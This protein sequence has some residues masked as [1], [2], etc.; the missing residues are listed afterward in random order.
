MKFRLSKQVLAA[1]LLVSI[2]PLLFAGITARRTLLE[3]L[4]ASIG[5]RLSDEV[6][7]TGRNAW[8]FLYVAQRDAQMI[9]SAIEHGSEDP[10]VTAQMLHDVITANPTLANLHVVDEHGRVQASAQREG[11]PQSIRQLSPRLQQLYQRA[12]NAKH[13]ETLFADLGEAFEEGAR[14]GELKPASTMVLELMAPVISTNGGRR[15]LIVSLNT[16]HV[17]SMLDGYIAE[18]G[19]EGAFIVDRNNRVLFSY[20]EQIRAGSLLAKEYVDLLAQFPFE[21]AAEQ[22]IVTLQGEKHFVTSASLPGIGA[23]LG[24]Q[25]RVMVLLPYKTA[26]A[27]IEATMRKGALAFLIIIVIAAIAAL[28][29]SRSIGRPIAMLNRS[30]EAMANGDYSIRVTGSSSFEASQL[31]DA[32][33]RMSVAVSSEKQALQ[34]EIAERK[35]AQAQIRELQHR[36]E[37]ILNNAGDGL[38]GLDHEGRITF[39]N[40]HGAEL[41]ALPMQRVIGMRMS[42]LHCDSPAITGTDAQQKV[43]EQTL[44]I[45]ATDATRE[46][47][48]RRGD[49]SERA[50]EYV[51]SPLKDDSGHY[52][53]SVVVFRDISERKAHEAEL[54]A[55]R[56]AAESASRAKSEFLANMSHEIRTPMN[57]V[58]G[59]TNLLGD[60]TLSDE[61]ADY[62]KTI[63]HSAESLL[64]IINDI[65]DFSKVEAGKLSVEKIPFRLTGAVSDVA[66]LLTPQAEQK[67]LE[68]ALRIPSGIP[69]SILGDPGRVRQIVLNLMGNAIKFTQRGHVLITL[70]MLPAS[71]ARPARIRCTIAD[72]GIGI[73]QEKQALM[74]QQF[75]QADASTTRTFG[76]TGLGLA[77]SKRLVELMGGEIGFSSQEGA[78]STFWFTLPAEIAVTA[79]DESQ[80]PLPNAALLNVLVVDDLEVNRRLFGQQLTDWQIKHACASSGEEALEVLQRARVQ[81]NPFNIAVLDH[82]MPGMDGL[83]LGQR[84]KA[85][86]Q[87]NRTS[88]IMVTSGSQ[89][90]AA[91]T[92]LT[93]GFD[94]FLMKPVVRPTQ[95]QVALAKAWRAVSNE[96]VTAATTKHA[97]ASP[98]SLSA[99]TGRQR[100]VLVAEDN[101]VNQR[102][103]KHL[104]EKKLHCLVDIAEDGQQAVEMTRNTEYD[105]VLMDCYMPVMDGFEATA[106][107]RQNQKATRRLPVVALTANAMAE[108]RERC[109][110]AGMDDYLS[111]PIYPDQLS[112][113]LQRWTQEDFSPASDVEPIDRSA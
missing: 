34:Q 97:S 79:A 5:P 65:L 99:P 96:S 41:L 23:N 81:G 105:L 95:L 69:E 7:T 46:A 10:A 111:K 14:Q 57:G 54:K 108:D 103:V 20:G 59:F 60:T 30:A 1:L 28:W 15:V 37:L 84:I 32:F 64:I 90:A 42:E 35:T 62:V 58:I 80:L 77:I 113:I 29:L 16:Q 52:G 93:A 4:E 13:G 47:S 25:W 56:V 98:S 87:L 107:I 101:A 72:T 43:L 36:Q 88:L 21:P 24:G 76:G 83:E 102:L 61:Q 18:T 6:A 73:A 92:F 51:A 100:R 91:E 39:I 22:K 48:I 49:G 12:L 9:R 19:A 109:L 82:L 27:S 94:V 67:G 44:I 40:R 55:A 85:D 71:N 17:M 104:L 53:G 89:R 38:L 112:R 78:G 70:E 2:I 8:V 3:N 26:A 75:A 31:A 68:V 66:E 86:P 106:A 110:A 11:A 50:I 63:R 74:F 33:N 45:D